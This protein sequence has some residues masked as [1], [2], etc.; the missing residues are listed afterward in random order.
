M[1]PFEKDE[2]TDRELD[3]MLPQWSAP[4]APAQLK[5]KVFAQ[6]WWRRLAGVS[7]RV[8]LPAACVLALAFLAA[9]GGWLRPSPPPRVV[10]QT[11][12]VE[13][14]ATAVRWQPVSELR[15]RIIRSRHD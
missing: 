5:A 1:E 15:P 13:S 8:P 9:A 4:E 12:T 14:P 7:I 2:L 11:I 6:P 3:A 10:V